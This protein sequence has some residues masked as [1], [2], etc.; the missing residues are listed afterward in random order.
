VDTDDVAVE[1]LLLQEVKRR[2]AHKNATNA[3]PVLTAL[4][5]P[6]VFMLADLL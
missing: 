6:T 5:T 4:D 3:S 2:T 1:L